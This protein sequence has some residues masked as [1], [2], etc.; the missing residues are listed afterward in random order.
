MC[1]NKDISIIAFIFIIISCYI[2]INL[3]NNKINDK[4]L[5]QNKIIGFY[6]LFVGIMQLIDYLIWID[7][8]CKKGFNKLSGILG[9][10]FNYLQPTI[11]ILAL[12]IFTKLNFKSLNLF[13]LFIIIVNIL[14]FIYIIITYFVYLK[15]NI[16]SNV[17]SG[18]LKWSWG[19]NNIWI[20][21][22]F[23]VSGL[24]LILYYYYGYNLIP[25][26]LGILFL[27]L[28]IIYFNQ[29]I[30]ELWC[31]FVVLIPI[32]EIIRQLIFY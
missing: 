31:F 10:L 4:Q 19:N 26:I 14:Y 29:N 8:D 16:C 18:H 3:N 21:L 11:L 1:W 5:K 25:M 13:E 23:I 15:G 28:S 30:G 32:L 27:V 22:Y 6:I 24:N 17:K 9:P 2:L 20:I 12:L 7:L